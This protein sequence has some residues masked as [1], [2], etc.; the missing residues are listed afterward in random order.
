[1]LLGAPGPEGQDQLI[2]GRGSLGRSGKGGGCPALCEPFLD[3]PVV[4]GDRLRRAV[5]AE[6]VLFA[7]DVD[8]AKVLWLVA[9]V[10]W[11]LRVHGCMANRSENITG[12]VFRKLRRPHPHTRRGILR[13]RFGGR[14]VQGG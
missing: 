6:I 5:P 1:M 8:Q 4:R 2:D 9:T 13:T 3:E 11:D 10:F 12:N 14:Y 7:V